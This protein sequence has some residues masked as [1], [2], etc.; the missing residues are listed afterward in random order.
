MTNSAMYRLL[1]L[2]A[3]AECNATH[4]EQLA[5][6]AT[7]L[8]G[9][10][11]VPAQAE[12]HG[13]AP[14]L[15]TH[16]RAAGVQLPLTIKRKLQG[17]YLRHRHANRVRTR[18]L[19]DVLAAYKAAGVQALVLKGAALSHLVYPEPGLRPMSD[20]DI[21]V[22]KSDLWRAQS[23]LADLGFDAPLPPGP[24]LPSRHLPV[25]T[26]QTEGLSIQVEIHYRLLSYYLDDA[27]SYR[28]DGLHPELRG[29]VAAS[30]PPSGL[31]R[32]RVGLLPPDLG[33]RR[34]QPGRA[35]RAGY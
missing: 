11:G 30:L 28:R 13:M 9:W 27:I 24:T 19:R 15:Y 34:R 17:L 32:Q 22:S 1:A 14:L 12:A 29:H 8:T 33:R 10:E 26:L 18:V 16:L 35:V 21:L 4:Y 20:L 3:R 23:L 7:Q 31:S 5:R 2:C 25:A 6:R